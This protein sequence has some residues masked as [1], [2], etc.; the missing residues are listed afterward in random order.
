MILAR[1]LD[2]I[3]FGRERAFLYGTARRV[4]ANMRRAV[5]RRGETDDG[6]LGEAPSGASLPDELVAEARDRAFLDELLRELP[7]EL[8]RVLVLAELEELVVPDIATLENIPVGTAASRLRRARAAFRDV[9]AAAQARK[10][11]GPTSE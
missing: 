11:L 5:K 7:D 8:R 9:L 2:D 3:E 10:P 6:V 1:R 4:L